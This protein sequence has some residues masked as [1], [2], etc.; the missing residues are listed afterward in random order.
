MISNQKVIEFGASQLLYH[1]RKAHLHMDFRVNLNVIKN[2]RGDW[3][4]E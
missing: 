1:Q 2:V 3:V 4:D